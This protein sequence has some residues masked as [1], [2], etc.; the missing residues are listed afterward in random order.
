MT[1]AAVHIVHCI[2]T[3][4]PLYE[5]LAA[6]FERLRDLFG[7][8]H[9]DPT[10][11]N[12]RRLQQGE[13]DLGGKEAQVQQVLSG[14]L[15]RYNE[16]WAD[17]DAMLERVTAKA[18]REKTLDS[19]GKG[20][21]FNWFCMDHVNYDYNPR[22]R[23]I[24]YHN[25]FDHYRELLATQPEAG[26]GLDWHFHPMS[27]YR[28]AHRCATHYF[29]SPEIF[30]ILARKVIERGW[31]PAA[32][33][34]GFQTERPD[35]H[36]FLEQWLPFDMSN[37]SLDDNS[38][39]DRSTDFRLGR[40]GDWRKAPADWSVYHPHHDDYQ[41]AGNCRRVIGRALNVLNRIASIDQREM[42][43][44]FARAASGLPAL[45]GIASHDWRDLGPEVDHIRS[46]VE[47]SRKRFPGVEVRFSEVREA[48]RSVLNRSEPPL[49][50]ELTFHPADDSDVAR[51]EVSTKRGQVFGPQPFL[52]IETL[53]R[54]FFHDNFDFDPNGTSWH[55]AFNES[56]VPL[57]D[58]ARIGV[59]A[60]GKGG[61]VSVKRFDFARPH[62]GQPVAY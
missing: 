4:G 16:T 27:S 3:E 40:S 29:R 34:A 28:D 49:E 62:R 21:R 9:L 20:W 2:D 42:D 10:M 46:L 26:D 61:H 60:A 41:V 56:T 45:V 15:T 55:Y 35:S 13:I 31:F 37:M 12:L 23:D 51:I 53:G 8:D 44:G 17:I 58:V 24:G 54:R 57:E 52:A 5:S 1:K 32:Y 19:D 47:E 30:Q 36:W 59:G 38:E 22:R 43:K 14:H 39:L 33:R 48:F 7:I 50:L 25:I 18:F 11:Q 6:K